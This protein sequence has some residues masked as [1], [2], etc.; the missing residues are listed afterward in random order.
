MDAVRTFS[1]TS[2]SFAAAHSTLAERVTRAEDAIAQTVDMLAQNNAILVQIQS[3]LGLP[4]IS[5]SVPPQAYL[6]S[7]PAEPTTPTHP[8][9]TTASLN[10]LVVAVDASPTSSAAP[11]PALDEDDIPLAAHH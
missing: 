8:A 11:H 10:L 7:S 2:A 9:P 1:A 6:S 4:S 5:P 3:H